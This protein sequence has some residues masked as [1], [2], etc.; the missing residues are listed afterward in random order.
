M[1]K[2]NKSEMTK[3]GQRIATEVIQVLENN[4]MY[5]APFLYSCCMAAAFAFAKTIGITKENLRSHIEE[6]L[7][8]Y[9]DL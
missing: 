1:K 8:H 4:A 9:D 7:E 3:A 6:G 5:N 2:D